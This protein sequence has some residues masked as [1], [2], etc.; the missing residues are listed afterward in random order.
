MEP[1]RSLFIETMSWLQMIH[2]TVSAAWWRDGFI[3]NE[4]KCI[5]CWRKGAFIRR[6]EAHICNVAKWK[7]EH[8]LFGWA[9]S[10]ILQ[11]LLNKNTSYFCRLSSE[12]LVAQCEG[13]PDVHA[14]QHAVRAPVE[15]KRPESTRLCRN[16]TKSVAPSSLSKPRGP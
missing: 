6:W 7:H 11:Y 10:C 15:S 5:T 9:V 1:A 12:K 4:L 8:N 14:V 13:G 16:D 2:W 3:S